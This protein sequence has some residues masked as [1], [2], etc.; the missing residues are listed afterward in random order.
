MLD[1]ARTTRGCPE[2][3]G[4]KGNEKKQARRPLKGRGGG[5]KE[6]PST[7]NGLESSEGQEF[8][9]DAE[10]RK[11]TP[12]EDRLRNWVLT[13][14]SGGTWSGGGVARVREGWPPGV[15]AVGGGLAARGPTREVEL[16]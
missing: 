2:G 14:G 12:S 11:R 7:Q 13:A 6:Q 8:K 1:Y 15:R 5:P 9:R 4:D 3:K 10:A 16:G